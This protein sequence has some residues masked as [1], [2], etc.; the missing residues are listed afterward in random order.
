M[1]DQI[2]LSELGL[3][4]KIQFADHIRAAIASM[5]RTYL[6]VMAALDSEDNWRPDGSTSMG[7]WVAA[8][9]A[10]T[11]GS[12]EEL[13]R[14]AHRIPKPTSTPPSANA[15]PTPSPNSRPGPWLLTVTPIWPA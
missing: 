7:R 14:V 10:L 9:H 3:D 6:K 5:H 11:A 8:R 2:D 15:A 1:Q 12:G 4:G 13:I